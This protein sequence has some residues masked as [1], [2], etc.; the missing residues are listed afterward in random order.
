MIMKPV[1]PI[2]FRIVGTASDGLTVTLG[3]YRS[4]E[5]AELDLARLLKQAHYRDVVIEAL[6]QP[7]ADERT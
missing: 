3:K 4:R 1:P 6:A 2:L 7:P 5:E